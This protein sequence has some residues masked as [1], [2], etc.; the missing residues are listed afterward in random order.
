MT[1][2]RRPTPGSAMLHPVTVAA[3]ALLILNDHVFKAQWPS[4][5]TGKLSDVAGLAMFPLLLQGLWEHLTARGGTDFQPSRAVLH[6]CVLLTGLCFSAIQVSALAGDGWRWGL[7]L[8][9]WPARAA[10]AHVM[11]APWHPRVLP[12]AHVADAEDLLALPA[13][14][15]AMKVGGQ[16]CAPRATLAAPA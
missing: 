13:L 3:V 1:T 10:W 9:Q 8:L 6:A 16:R 15:V 4:W 5:W 7:G 14:W 11:D 2:A 12:V